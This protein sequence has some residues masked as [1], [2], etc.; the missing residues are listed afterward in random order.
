MKH[1]GKIVI[2]KNNYMKPDQKPKPQGDSRHVAVTSP[3][4]SSSLRLRGRPLTRSKDS[5]SG[6]DLTEEKTKVPPSVSGRPRG[7]PPKK[8][9]EDGSRL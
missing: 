7:R 6:A 9:G 4:V 1:S 3:S 5:F 8:E 2:V